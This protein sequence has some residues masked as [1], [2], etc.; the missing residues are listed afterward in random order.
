MPHARAFSSNGESATPPDL[1]ESASVCSDS[2]AEI[3]WDH[4]SEQPYPI[5]HRRGIL[6]RLRYA[7]L[8]YLKTG[9]LALLFLPLIAITQL[10]LTSGYRPRSWI[11]P[12][13][14]PADFAGL[15]VALHS[16]DGPRLAEEINELGVR[17]I[18]LRIPTWELDRLDEY[19]AFMDAIPDCHIV[20]CIMQNRSDVTELDR[21]RRQLRTIIEA[22]WPRV[23]E[24]Q[25][26]QGSNRSKWGFFSTEEYLR[27]A[28]VAEE[29]RSD[30]PEIA[31]VGPGTLDFETMPLLRALVHGYPIRWDAVGCA[32]YIDRRGSPSGRQ[33]LFFNLRQKILHFASCVRLANKAERR[34]W[35]TEVNWPLENQGPY[36]P[37][38]EEDCISEEATAAYLTEYYK[39]A[40][41]TGLVE[42]VYWWQLVSKG[43]G[44]IDVEDDGSLRRRP[45][46][47]AFKALLEEENA[48]T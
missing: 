25:I 31:F 14:E 47:Y 32:L 8:D 23:T 11:R 17:R 3:P 44:L 38:G 12:R 29:L 37:T 43:F 5:R 35:I 45:A 2:F 41:D 28:S 48:R 21:W 9:L 7:W 18:L 34:F 15:A 13:Q 26:G 46:Y 39:T 36:S 6:T 22:C 20:V 19:L 30:F 42:R 24:F 16:C 10:G 1:G 27:F 33:L 40:M 4:H